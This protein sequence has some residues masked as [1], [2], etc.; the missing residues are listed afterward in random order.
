MTFE[1]VQPGF[2][3]EVRNTLLAGAVRWR[4]RGGPIETIEPRLNLPWCAQA[5]DLVRVGASKDVTTL[6]E[7]LANR[8]HE[9]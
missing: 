2:G 3:L 1:S 9:D 4:H 8:M 5:N 7:V 6:R